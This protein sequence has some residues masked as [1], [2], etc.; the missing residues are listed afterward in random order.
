M[1][2]TLTIALIIILVAS[3]STLLLP[4]SAMNQPSVPEF[5]LKYVDYS[6]DTP[7]T[8]GT[9]PY[10]GQTIVTNPSNHVDNRTVQIVIKNQ[11]FT[12]YTD[13]NGIAINLFYNVRYKGSFG[14]DWTMMFGEQAQ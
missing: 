11:P 14:E 5:T 9:D 7:V 4:V 10:T 13:G 1:K 12:P 6:Y 8:Y 3:S 2:R